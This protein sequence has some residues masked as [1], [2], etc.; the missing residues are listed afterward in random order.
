MKY[1]DI[2]NNKFITNVNTVMKIS[3][4]LGITTSLNHNLHKYILCVQYVVIQD[5]RLL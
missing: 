3:H 1:I 5:F 4:I 2:K